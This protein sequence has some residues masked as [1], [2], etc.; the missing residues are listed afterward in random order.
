[1]SYKDFDFFDSARHASESIDRHF[2][3]QRRALTHIDALAT[4]LRGGQLAEI[5][6]QVSRAMEVPSAEHATQ[7]IEKLI[8]GATQPE[9]DRQLQR[10][11][12]FGAAARRPSELDLIHRDLGELLDPRSQMKGFSADLCALQIQLEPPRIRDVFDQLFQERADPF[13]IAVGKLQ[14]ATSVTAT[15]EQMND[16]RGLLDTRLAFDAAS[17]CALDELAPPILGLR[18]KD[19]DSPVEQIP[20]S[21]FAGTI[22]A[23]RA[24]LPLKQ[25]RARRGGRRMALLA[26]PNGCVPA[27]QLQAYSEFSLLEA[28]IRQ[29]VNVCLIRHLGDDWHLSPPFELRKLA[30]DEERLVRQPKAPGESALATL[31]FHELVDIALEFGLDLIE[32]PERFRSATVE[33]NRSRRA[34]M[35][36]RVL[37][38]E[39]VLRMVILARECI[40]AIGYLIAAVPHRR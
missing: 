26:K 39:A 33:L 12:E 30:P 23:L 11:S 8:Y 32:Q 25:A 37:T 31:Y 27:S 21:V 6:A 5:E 17:M 14:H 24:P 15:L 22:R 1:M 10:F 4:T 34:V 36:G 19:P 16:L 3:E 35:H 13:R 40:H 7:Q 20:K 28:T 38:A 9:V 18:R 2:R 29:F